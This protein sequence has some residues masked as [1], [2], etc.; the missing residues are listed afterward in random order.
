MD[1]L[2]AILI[3]IKKWGQRWTS[4]LQFNKHYP[5]THIS[6]VA[7]ESTWYFAIIINIATLDYMCEP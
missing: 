7:L 5:Q 2:Y 6:C 4:N 1:K 3:V